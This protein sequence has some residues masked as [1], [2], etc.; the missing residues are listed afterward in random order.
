MFKL[1]RYPPQKI[2]SSHLNALKKR[3]FDCGRR[4]LVPVPKPHYSARALCVSCHVVRASFVF[5][6]VT[7]MH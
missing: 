2:Q 7:E 3:V 6:Y 4:C 5:G 1:G